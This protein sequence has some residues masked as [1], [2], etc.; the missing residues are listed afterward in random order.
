MPL[1][2]IQ[3]VRQAAGL[4]ARDADACATGATKIQLYMMM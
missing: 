1:Q 4:G 3:R 2:Q